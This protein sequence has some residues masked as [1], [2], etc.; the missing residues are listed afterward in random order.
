MSKKG[1]RLKE[2]KAVQVKRKRWMRKLKRAVVLILELF[3]FVV[4]S[5]MMYAMHKYGKIDFTE[6]ANTHINDGVKQEGYTTIVLFGGDSRQ[7]ELEAGT[8]ADTMMI[9]SIDNKTKEVKIVSLY[10]DTTLLQMNGEIRKANSAYFMGG[11]QEAINMLNKNLDLDIQDYVT[12]D[13]KALADVI[14]LLGGL[15]IEVSAEEAAEMNRYIKE[16][17]KVAG[18]EAILVSEGLQTLDGVQSVTYARIRKIA[19]GDYARTNRQ[20]LVVEEVV[21]KVKQTDL[22]TINDIIDQVFS[23]VSTSFTLSEIVKLATGVM[24]Y[25]IGGTDGF[26][27]ELTDGPVEGLGSVVIPLGFVENVQELHEF[28]YPK[29]GYIVSTDV[30]SIAWQIEALTGYTRDDYI[31]PAETSGT[32]EEVSDSETEE[33]KTTSTEE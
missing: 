25:D 21:E 27:F 1:K 16:T 7:G 8:H 9:A 19:G 33:T 5:T 11:P 3:V 22:G 13:F 14:D 10:R 28:L 20:R 15:E 6:L 23:Q 18:K 2:A 30:Q 4:L 32:A 26:P 24:Q 29:D 12:V 31:P 17:A